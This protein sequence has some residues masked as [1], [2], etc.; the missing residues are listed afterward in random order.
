LFYFSLNFASGL[1]VYFIASNL[2]GIAQYAALG[3]VNW[4]N[5][6]KFGPA[7]KPEIV[8]TKSGKKRS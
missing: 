3:K 4:S 7:K 1:A 5:L 8:K 6:F 2:F